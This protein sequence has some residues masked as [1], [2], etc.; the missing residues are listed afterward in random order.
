MLIAT[1]E[2]GVREADVAKPVY[3]LVAVVSC[4]GRP[5]VNPIQADGYREPV[6]KMMGMAT[7]DSALS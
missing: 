4:F 2:I 5:A 6:L 3:E 7:T 1:G